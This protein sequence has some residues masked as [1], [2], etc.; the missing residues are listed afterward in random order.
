MR[1]VGIIASGATETDAAVILNEDEEKLVKTEDLVLIA[2]KCGNK[3]LA[4]CRGGLGSN[5]NLRTGSY[6]P[7]VA[8]ARMGR[9][10]S[11]AKEFYQFGL[12]VIGDVTGELAQ[13]KLIL[14]PSSD[15]EVFEDEDNPMRYLGPGE[16]SIGFYKE[17]PNW[18]VPIN[19]K[20]IPYH[21][22]IFGVTGAG[23][24]FLARYQVIPLL[25]KAGYDVI[26]FDWKG[27][28]Y[29]PYFKDSIVLRDIVLDE[30]VVTSYLADAMDYFGF[31]GEK[32]SINPIVAALEDVLFNGDWRKAQPGQVKLFLE[33]KVKE[34]IANENRDARGNLTQWG[35]LYLTKFDRGMARLTERD[36]EN[37]RGEKSHKDILSLAREKH[38]LVL[39]ISQGSKEEKLSVFMSFARYLRRRM[40]QKER[41]NLALLVDEGPQ[42]CPFK[43]SG[44]EEDT[45]EMMSELCALGRT[46]N[47]SIVLL[48]QGIAGEIGINAAVRRNL[49][50]QFIGKIH[51]L[52]MEEASKL[53]LQLNIDPKFLVSLPEGHFYFLGKMNPSPIPLLISFT[54]E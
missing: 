32:K 45:T 31:T 24:S 46:Y 19:E 12:S 40:E 42:Y 47:L 14:A 35:R 13:N 17:H 33:T 5:E 43:P 29:A 28:D 15:V 1:K 4:V 30:E 38:I 48:S 22:G 39:D 6:S 23:K 2:N 51:P 18:S 36:F 7:G 34:A 41:L 52:D 26:I 50:T 54:I 49:N 37:V 25:N 3:V 44:M 20:F 16:F 53:L 21:I 11:S 9:H 8:Y 27:S 10:P